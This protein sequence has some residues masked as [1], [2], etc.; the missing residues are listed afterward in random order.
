[1]EVFL[2][3]QRVLL[4]FRLIQKESRKVKSQ[5][6]CGVPLVPLSALSG[7]LSC[8]FDSRGASSGPYAFAAP[9]PVIGILSIAHELPLQIDQNI[10]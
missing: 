3:S 9:S 4:D 8:R 10:E 6:G 2:V 5:L 1:V 7:I